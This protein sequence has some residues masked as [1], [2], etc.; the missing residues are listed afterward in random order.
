[1]EKIPN[2]EALQ[3][4][5][6]ADI[7]FDQCLVGFHGF[8]A[9]EGLALGKPV[10][11]FIRKPQEYLLHPEECPFI[12]VNAATLKQDILDLVRD[13]AR[14]TTIG[15]D[16]RRYIEKYFSLNAFAARLQNAYQELG[17]PSCRS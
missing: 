16:G 2:V 5:R 15:Q 1:M 6:S 13:R 14:L 12:N 7:I 8:F 9:L 11:V 4:Y 10:M 17:I 3:I